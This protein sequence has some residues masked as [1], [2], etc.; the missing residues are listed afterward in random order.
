MC[1]CITSS[2]IPTHRGSRIGL[3]CL[4]RRVGQRSMWLPV[5]GPQR[6]RSMAVPFQAGP[7]P[8]CAALPDPFCRGV[9][10]LGLCTDD[11]SCLHARP[12]VIRLYHAQ[13]LLSLQH[14]YLAWLFYPCSRNSCPVHQATNLCSMLGKITKYLTVGICV[15]EQIDLLRNCCG[16][17][18]FPLVAVRMPVS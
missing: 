2:H 14:W 1:C 13:V 17:A 9:Q 3:R 16:A 10:G 8:H 6:S 4:L 7:G 18:V 15:K 12:L 5:H 11:Q